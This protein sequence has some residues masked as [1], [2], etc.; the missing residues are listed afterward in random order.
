MK[1]EIF[2]KQAQVLRNKKFRPRRILGGSTV[3]GN[4]V[5][6]PLAP[7]LSLSQL[8]TAPPKLPRKRNTSSQGC[9]GCKR[10]LGG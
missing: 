10:T 7:K 9:S 1:R 3:I 5:K 6:T 4:V 2:I 8:P